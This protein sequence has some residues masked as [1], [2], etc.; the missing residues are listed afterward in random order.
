VP[1]NDECG[2]EKKIASPFENT[3]DRLRSFIP[4]AS[5]Q[6]DVEDKKKKK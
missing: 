2:T 5:A 4:A 3:Q 1:E 6:D